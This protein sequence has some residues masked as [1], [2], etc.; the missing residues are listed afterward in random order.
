MPTLL[1]EHS[2]AKGGNVL[3]ME[4]LGKNAILFQM[5]H[6]VRTAD[7][8]AVA[9]ERLLAMH[10]TLKA[11]DQEQ[12]IHVEWEYLGYADGSQDPL[13]SYGAVNVKFLREVAAVYDPDQVF[14]TR[15]PGGFKISKVV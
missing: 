2:T 14:Q 9:R 12:G 6:M 15:V 1:F 5:Q 4:G 7:E 13:S 11:Y 8:E 10:D 3:G